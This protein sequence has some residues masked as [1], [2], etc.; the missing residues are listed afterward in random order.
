MTSNKE[1]D[2]LLQG[3]VAIITGAG[4]GMGRETALLFAENGARVAVVDVN[5]KGA[6]E[7][8]DSITKK[9][10]DAIAVFCDVTDEES[11]NNMAAVVLE[12]Y[13]RIDILHMNAGIVIPYQGIET[14]TVKDFEKI[15]AINARGPFLN[16]K[17]VVPVMKKQGG[18][19]MLLTSS[20]SALRPRPGAVAYAS[21]KGAA[22]LLAKTLAIELAPFN[23]R[24]N[25]ICPVA[26]DTPLLRGQ[27]NEDTMKTMA[28]GVPLGRLGQAKDMANAALFLCSDNASFIT[29]I[30]M[31]VD[32]GRGI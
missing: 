16:A 4:S 14:I 12:K 27:V 21:S 32:G 20:M 22:T 19:V 26:T 5:M 24:V 18:G 1:I 17:A 31:E 3:K 30:T 11:N 29:G 9:G 23:I 2:M 15:F 8:V 10:G 25:T 28:A 6:Q 13:G 7:T